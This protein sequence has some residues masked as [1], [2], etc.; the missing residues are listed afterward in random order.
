MVSVQKWAACTANVRNLHLVVKFLSRNP[1][2]EKD[3]Q[4]ERGKGRVQ[5]HEEG[6]DGNERRN[7]VGSGRRQWGKFPHEVITIYKLHLP[8]TSCPSVVIWFRCLVAPAIIA[9]PKLATSTFGVLHDGA[10]PT[11]IPRG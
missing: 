6:G 5:E 4:E 8:Y 9:A 11:I 1:E 2:D 10:L 7:Q 3:E